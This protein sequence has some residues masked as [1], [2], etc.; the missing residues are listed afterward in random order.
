[1]IKLGHRALV[2]Q[3]GGALGAYEAGVFNVLYSWIKKDLKG[4]ENIFDVVAGTSIGAINGAILVSHVKEKRIWE[5]SA[6]KLVEFWENIKINSNIEK[7]PF[8]TS[9]WQ[10]YH[11]MNPNAASVEA[12]R[13]YYSARQFILSGADKVF[14]APHPQLDDRF[15]DPSSFLGTWY[16]YDNSKLRQSIKD[17]VTFPIRTSFDKNEP[18]LLV[19]SVDIEEAETVTFDSYVK[20]DGSRMSEYGFSEKTGKNEQRVQYD[21][22]LMVEHIMASASVPVHYDYTLIPSHYDYTKKEE[23]EE[24]DKLKTGT[25]RNN[26]KDYRRFWDGGILS[27]TP[28]R[29]L[30]QAH[31]D[32]WKFVEK[33]KEVPNLEVYIVDVWSSMDK[34]PLLSDYD[35]VVDRRNGFT[36]QDK[37]PYD[38]KVANIVS[39]YHD[40]SKSL[41]DLAK[42]IGIPQGDIETILN[43]QAKSSHRTGEKRIYHDLLDKRF[44]ITKLVRIERSVDKD[45]ISN[46]WADFSSG[47]ISKLLKQ[48]ID[49]ALNSLTKDVKKSKG[50]HAAYDQIDAFINEIKKQNIEHQNANLIKAAENTRATLDIL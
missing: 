17:N 36:Y 46:K 18:R 29:E 1:M 35:S 41:I 38:E 50:I 30:I 25:Q 28:L 19:V 9:R 7:D 45:D 5:G 22:G 21:Q 43:R 11:R 10:Q 42:H 6:D 40:L 13:R 12:A 15:F 27:N 20:E 16:K 3:G 48:G 4:S 2:L 44:D 37:T 26:Q 32:Y 49:D 34:Y 31:Q 47:T 24:K 14:S 33:I 23:N 39:D 8:F